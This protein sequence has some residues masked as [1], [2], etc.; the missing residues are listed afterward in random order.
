MVILAGVMAIWHHS[1]QCALLPSLCQ[2][3]SLRMVLRA[4]VDDRVI[5]A[6]A[7]SA[8]GAL[9]ALTAAAAASQAADLA[10]GFIDHPSKREALATRPELRSQV[11]N[12]LAPASPGQGAR[13]KILGV[14]WFATGARRTP[15]V[16]SAAAAFRRRC[17]RIAVAVRQKT[18]RARFVR[19]LA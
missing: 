18:R 3:T 17:L 16:A 13:I 5:Y 4:Y 9:Q 1:A 8:A 15:F 10:L 7:R 2:D 11:V 19:S 12:S 14:D 6:R